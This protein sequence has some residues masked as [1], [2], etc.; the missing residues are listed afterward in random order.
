MKKKIFSTLVFALVFGSTIFA[1]VEVKLNP[2]GLLWGGVT[3]SGEVILSENMGAELTLGLANTNLTIFTGDNTKTT[4]FKGTGAF[5]YYFSPIDG[6]DGFYAGAYVKYRLLSGKY[7]SSF[8]NQS[9]SIDWNKLAVGLL[10]GYKWVADSGLLFEISGGF[11]RTFVNNISTTE[12]DE[13]YDFS[14]IP[15]FNFD[16]VGRFAVGYRF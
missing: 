15:F 5:K 10:T 3:A 6:G 2:I 13:S 16:L 7:D 14:D 8:T 12:D 11:G 4:G 9:E 1:Q